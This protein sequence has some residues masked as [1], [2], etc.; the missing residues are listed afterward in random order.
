MAFRLAMM[1]VAGLVLSSEIEPQGIAAA[2]LGGRVISPAGAPVAAARLEL[3]NVGTGTVR[4]ALTTNAG[5]FGFENVPVGRYHLDARAIGW[6]PARLENIDLHIGD[7]II[8]DVVLA[9]PLATVLE[10][11]VITEP[12]LRHAGAGGAA[13]W[14]PGAAVRGLPLRDRNFLGLLAMAPQATG[15]GLL[16]VGGQHTRFNAIQ[17]DGG[18]SGD[19]FGVNATPGSAAGAKVISLEA[20]EEIRILVAPFDVRQGGFS[21]GLI[22][23]VTRSGTNA[24]HGAL[25]ATHSRASL[26]GSD[27]SGSP[28]ETF[29]LLQYGVRL[30]GPI[31]RDRLHWVGVADI[32]SRE[33]PFV[34][35]AASDPATGISAATAERVGRVIRERYGFDPGGPDSPV[36]GQPNRN[37]F[38][39]LSWQASASHWLELSQSDVIARTDQLDR[40]TRNSRSRDG[41]QLAR[42][43]QVVSD[44]TVTTRLNVTSSIGAFSNELITSL[45]QV[46]DRKQST[47]G[48]PLFLVQGDLPN[49]YL[50]AGSA[51]SAQGTETSH[52][53]LEATNNLSW[54][55]NSHLLTLGTQNQLLDFRDNL[56][57][58]SWGV[59]TFASADALERDEPSRYEV[60]LPLRP[61]GPLAKFRALQLAGYIQ[62]QWNPLADL[63]I[64]LGVRADVPI[65]SHP[66]RNESLLA[67]DALGRVDTGKFPSGNTQLAPRIGFVWAPGAS[68]T[69][70]IRGGIGSFTGHPI[71]AWLATAFANTGL[72]QTLLVCEARDGVPAPTMD[73]ATLPRQCLN[74]P[75]AASAIPTV[76]VFS[77][78]FRYQQTVK[79]ALGM[80]RQVGGL[81]GSL[82]IVHS[83]SRHQLSVSDA[84]LVERGV[85]GEGRMM[86]GTISGTG[87][88]RPTRRDSTSIGPLFR[89]ENA[90]GDHSTA[91]AVSLQKSWVRGGL[92]H[93]GYSWSRAIDL[94]SF[95]GFN[96]QV[97]LQNAPVDRTLGRRAARRSVRDIPHNVT[98]SAIVPMPL[99]LTTSLFLRARSGTPYAWGV[100]G[101]A[102]ADNI[103][104]DDL[105]YVPRD[106]ADISLSNPQA[107]R[108]LDAFVE[109]EPCLRKQRGRVMRRA[110]CRNPSVA[111]LD[112][113]VSKTVRGLDVRADVFNLPN[114]VRHDW[115]IVRETNATEAKRGPLSVSGWNA[116]TNRP[117][118]AVVTSANGTPVFPGR[119]GVVVD[120]SRWR[121]Q[122][123]VRYDF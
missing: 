23:A 80:D 2:A 71:Y 96:G 49:N 47:L 18:S 123:S 33:T 53:V 74:G 36:I 106:S 119:N 40:T 6:T 117:R 16:S 55:R 14:I 45:S 107:Y 108:A 83:R 60:A 35:P 121:M 63:T 101:D 94:M 37:L 100:D 1:V 91:V 110:S 29:N 20:L 51:K 66:T 10:R 86:Y 43:G 84:N 89:F 105:L 88:I 12:A 118:Y 57:P 34:G 90:S 95:T 28:I 52:R 27:T 46:S 8:R 120:A 7:R 81:V 75:T 122:L 58:G 59:W 69:T 25:F 41:W 9:A 111:L 65:L 19:F 76:S 97:I 38:L 104:T 56:F 77:P 48:V 44:R 98:A 109:S 31:V 64:T 50:A 79:Y 22:N 62:D 54:A 17:V 42:S 68:R 82:D 24:L 114:L 15:T 112:A 116:T 21:G 113:S 61:G 85:N 4:T 3:T 78:R 13:Y 103:V 92:L 73:I 70:T 93:A 99:G 5:R 39:K 32:Q 115:G 102:N 11:V 67:N 26:V 30:G 72:D 87:T